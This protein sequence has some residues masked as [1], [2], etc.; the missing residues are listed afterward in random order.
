MRIRYALFAAPLL[1]LS[2]VSLV[3]LAQPRRAAKEPEERAPAGKSDKP[4]AKPEAVPSNGSSDDLGGPPPKPAA[5]AEAK[6]SPLNPEAN[7]FPDGGSQTP[8][9]EYDKLLGDIAALRSRVSAV[10]TT[11]F[12]SKV[13]VVVETRGSD[14]RVANFTVTLDDGVVFTAPD[15]FIAEDE[16][17]VYEHAVAPGHHVV[18][19]DIERFDARNKEYR[20]WQSS[21]FSVVI[22]ESKTVDAHVIIQDSSDM[23]KDFPSDQD[24]EYDLRVRLRARV[25]K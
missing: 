21:R 23:G 14:A 17:T 8:P 20:T 12:A 6:L 22:P 25:Q 18:G 9:V 1:L 13:R 2:L 4:E 16:R 19:I 10:T 5:T 15:R 3:A 11:L 24:G 7:E